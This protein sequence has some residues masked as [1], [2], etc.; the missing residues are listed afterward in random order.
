M[1]K[2]LIRK[3]FHTIGLD[4]R[5]Y[6]PSPP[7]PPAPPPPISVRTENLKLYHTVTGDYWLP[8]D[9]KLDIVRNAIIAN[10]IFDNDIFAYAKKYIE[11]GSVVLDVGANFGQMSV[12]FSQVTGNKGKVYSFEAED[13]VFDIL[14]KNI[15]ENKRDNIIPVFGAVYD[16]TGEKL[17]FPIPDFKRFPT[18]GSY[19][20]DYTNTQ[21]GRE[22]P[23]LTIDSLNID[24][25]VSFIKI[26]VQGGDLCV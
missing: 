8:E 25:K 22:V 1:I 21:I 23:T 12:L 11:E 16:S 4:I 7:L 15:A 24:K 17:V 26:D 14:K 9:A 6:T 5:R 3:T 2:R 13:F 20:P 19:G 18:W 10:Q